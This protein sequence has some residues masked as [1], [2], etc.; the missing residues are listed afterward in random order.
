MLLVAYTRRS[1]DR[2]EDSQETQESTIRAWCASNGHEVV[3]VYHEDPTSGGTSI[4]DRRV[5]PQLL[6]D[7]RDRRR[8]FDGVIVTH[9]DRLFR[10]VLG[11]CAF[12][13]ELKKYKCQLLSIHSPVDFDS[14][15]G[16]AM[17]TVIATFSQLERRTT[18]LRIRDSNLARM[19]K[20]DWPGGK[21]PLGLSYDRPTKRIYANERA[22]DVK[23]VF[24][25][26]CALGGNAHQAAVYLNRESIPTATGGLWTGGQVRRIIKSPAYRR[27]FSYGGQEKEAPRAIPE[28]A[29]ASL[30]EQAQLLV[31]NTKTMHAKQL[32]SG[33][34]YSG[35]LSCA[36]CG[37]RLIA[38]RAGWL[39]RG[40]RRGTC[41][42]RRVAEKYIDRLMGQAMSYL[43][44]QFETDLSARLA[45]QPTESIVQDDRRKRLELS[46]DRI[47]EAWIDGLIS[48]GQR[49]SRLAEVDAELARLQEAQDKPPAL[50]PEELLP[51]ITRL[52]EHWPEVPW[53]ERRNLLLILGVRAAV[54]TGERPV[55]LDFWCDE[56]IPPARFTLPRSRKAPANTL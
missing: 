49:D 22:P 24:R 14:P 28:I 36:V 16:E 8:D 48:R 30:V 46:R 2:Q 53:D 33:R 27:C 40:R 39:C 13:A 34:V 35:I 19:A 42:G 11:H 21:L 52:A 6:A 7:V 10:D 17:S 51:L 54:N 32:S 12:L 5:L 20:G 45:A 38:H 47:L 1:T 26:F 41:S 9:T 31:R 44:S 50:L 4:E 56:P 37:Q 55:F 29:P 25:A 15:M 18:G 43:L 3:R 23:E